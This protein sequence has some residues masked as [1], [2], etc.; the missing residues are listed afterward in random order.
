M[1]ANICANVTASG[2]QKN[3]QWYIDIAADVHMT[4]NLRLYINSNLDPI[5]E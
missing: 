2:K 4:N 5:Q 1:I 3:H